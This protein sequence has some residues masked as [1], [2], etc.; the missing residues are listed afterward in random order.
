MVFPIK[1]R[2][3]Q[4]APAVYDSLEK[5]KGADVDEHN[6]SGEGALYLHYNIMQ[7]LRK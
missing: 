3:K 1:Q 4:H 6:K 2:Q 5:F 7:L